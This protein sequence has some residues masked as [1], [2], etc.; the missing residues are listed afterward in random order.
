MNDCKEAPIY[1]SNPTVRSLWREYR[2]Y[3]DRLELDTFPFG[4][5][6]VP[7]SDLKAVTIRPPMVIFDVFR[8]D[9]K[10]GEILR[11]PKLD[12]AD[13]YEH[14]ALEKN[15]FW[16]QFRITPDDPAAFKRAVDQA[17]ASLTRHTAAQS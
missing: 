6:C 16:K 1:R 14:V 9:Y 5:V 7:L 12:L 17:L 8:G 3:A 2:L 4:T 11:A 10:L 15:G 13:L